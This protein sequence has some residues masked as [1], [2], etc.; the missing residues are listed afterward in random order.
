MADIYFGTHRPESGSRRT[1]FVSYVLLAA[2][3]ALAAL[4]QILPLVLPVGPMYWDVLLYYDAIGR[5]NAGQWPIL[6]FQVPVG[7]LE[8][9]LAWLNYQIFPNAHPLLLSQLEWLPITAPAMAL[10]VW[11]AHKRSAMAVWGLLVAWMLYTALPFNDMIYNNFAGSDGYGVYNRH[12]SHLMFLT[13]AT[14][15]FV[16]SRVLQTILLSVLL[17]SLAFCKITAFGAVG[18]LLVLGLLTRRIHP[19]VAL[20]TALI[21]IGLTGVLQ[22]ATGVVAGYVTDILVL[23]QENSGTLLP[24]FLTAIS[25]RFD[26]L[27]AGALLCLA[28]F[29]REVLSFRRPRDREKRGLIGFLD[30]D[31]V[32]IGL[33]LF[34]GLVFETQNTGGQPYLVVWPAIL[35]MLL[36]P[37][38]VFGRARFLIY[39]LAAFAVI[40]AVSTI[41]HKAA[42]VA[43]LGNTYVALDEPILGPIGRVSAKDVYVEQ[44]ER[45][46]SYYIANQDEMVEIANTG[47][48]PSFRMFVEHDYQ[49]LLIQEMGRAARAVERLEARTGEHFRS[50]LT[51]DFANPFP[52]ILKRP[53]AER[54]TIGADPSRSIPTP[55]EATLLAIADTDLILAPK[56]PFHRARLEV[57]E[58]YAPAL[59]DRVEAKLTPCYD[60]LLKPD[61]PFLKVLAPAGAAGTGIR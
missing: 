28:L 42:R 34:C 2:F 1:L 44:A 6:D 56:C 48:L 4:V 22:L 31:W 9:W 49:Y 58:L 37:S 45:M 30:G 57:L 17:L 24:R 12:G 15:L 8:Y 41:V 11:D 52:F 59:T 10:I 36:R 19:Y 25:L 26:I 61:S 3:L 14:V 60:V 50:V 53:G 7:P 20:S 27:A 23:A 55:D 47:A 46:R 32:W 54:V 39:V 40:P 29:W 13:A 33:S 5:M 51:L 38:D 43:G 16:R 21:C 18:P 35:R